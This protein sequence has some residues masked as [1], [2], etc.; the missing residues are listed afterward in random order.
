MNSLT[1]T[2]LS[3]ELLPLYTNITADIGA[4]PSR[5]HPS[6]DAMPG[7][8]GKADPRSSNHNFRQEMLR[9]TPFSRFS[10]AT[11]GRGPLG[12]ARGL[13]GKDGGGGRGAPKAEQLKTS[14]AAGKAE[15]G[16]LS[17][18]VNSLGQAA[19]REFGLSP[20]PRKEAAVSGVGAGTGRA[21]AA[22]LASALRKAPDNR[23]ALKSAD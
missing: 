19:A 17:P 13:P 23:T 18:A 5:R 22:T 12:T 7:L 16:S 6:Q 8:K 10:P 1:Y 9:K 3:K 4:A 20:A 21:G 11:A 14:P 15:N 2:L